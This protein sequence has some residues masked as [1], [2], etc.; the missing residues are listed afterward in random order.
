MYRFINTNSGLLIFDEIMNVLLLS[1][2]LMM[3]SQTGH[4]HLSTSQHQT[5]PTDSMSVSNGFIQNQPSLRLKISLLQNI[6]YTISI[7]NIYLLTSRKY[8]VW[9][10]Y[11]VLATGCCR[12]SSL[13]KTPRPRMST[14]LTLCCISW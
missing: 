13:P 10:R 7:V 1:P 6:I 2:Q 8:L 11:L 5:L 12:I 14:S 9:W 3:S 4:W